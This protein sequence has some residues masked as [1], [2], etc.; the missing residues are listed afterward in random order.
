VKSRL[1]DESRDTPS[2]NRFACLNHDKDCVQLRTFS[3]VYTRQRLW[4]LTQATDQWKPSIEQ[5]AAKNITDNKDDKFTSPSNG[6]L[7]SEKNGRTNVSFK[8]DSESSNF[9]STNAAGVTAP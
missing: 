8:D 4:K 3:F 2:T 5:T 7:T 6:E 1:C 9:D